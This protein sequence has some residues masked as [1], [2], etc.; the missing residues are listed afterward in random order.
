MPPVMRDPIL[1][2]LEAVLHYMSHCIF[3]KLSL[4]EW[5]LSISSQ[6]C[7]LLLFIYFEPCNMVIVFIFTALQ[8]WWVLSIAVWLL[9][10]YSK[11]KRLVIVYFA[12]ALQYGYVYLYCLYIVLFY[13]LLVKQYDNGCYPKCCSSS[14]SSDK[15]NN[16]LTTW[17]L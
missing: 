7:I 3:L 16:L 12:R 5:L 6:P 14:H 2:L 10:I 13:I 8:Y 4:A 11:L 15:M 1:F 17:V 9:S